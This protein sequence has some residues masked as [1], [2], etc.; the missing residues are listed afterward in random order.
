[1]ASGPT[2]YSL[3]IDSS[4]LLA[5]ELREPGYEE[6]V[7]KLSKTPNPCIG[8]PTLFEATMVWL[9]RFQTDPRTTL[10]R[11]LQDADADIVAFDEECYEI[12]LAAFQKY[13]KGRHPAALNFGDCM[14]YAIAVDQNVPLL[15]VGN[16]FLKTDIRRA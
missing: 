5:I 13:G 12:A 4:A 15:Y 2:A 7:E 10:F 8:A 11:T 1:M 14:A 16:D 6:L 3:A 9:N